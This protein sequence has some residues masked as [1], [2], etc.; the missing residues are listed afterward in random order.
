MID[1]DLVDAAVTC[2]F[3]RNDRVINLGP[4]KE[5][6]M[7]QIDIFFQLKRTLFRRLIDAV[8]SDQGITVVFN[9]L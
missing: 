5:F 7:I 8:A 3:R 1:C 6:L 9:I 4:L 2:A